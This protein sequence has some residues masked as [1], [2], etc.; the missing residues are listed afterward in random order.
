MSR[1]EV[2]ERK[3]RFCLILSARDSKRARK[4]K[5][6]VLLARSH[7]TSRAI[8]RLRWYVS[9]FSLVFMQTVRRKII[10]R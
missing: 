8:S 10:A 2:L 4:T 5:L 3:K 7:T 1:D 9:L 6:S